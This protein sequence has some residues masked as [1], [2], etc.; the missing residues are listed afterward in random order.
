MQQLEWKCRHYVSVYNIFRS[1]CWEQS[2]KLKSEW[3]SCKTSVL[4]CFF[5]Y[6]RLQVLDHNCQCFKLLVAAWQEF[7]QLQNDSTLVLTFCLVLCQLSCF[8]ARW[9]RIC[10][11]LCLYAW[12]FWTPLLALVNWNKNNNKLICTLCLMKI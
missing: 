8:C 9:M 11:G 7:L 10:G 6:L 4:F 2:N 1:H 3:I 5:F 12:A